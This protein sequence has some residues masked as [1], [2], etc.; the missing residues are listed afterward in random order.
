[1]SSKKLVINNIVKKFN[2]KVAVNGVSLEVKSNEITA[3]LGPNGSG[4]TTLFSIITGVISQTSGSV[5]YNDL[6]ISRLSIDKRARLGIG[7]LTQDS[8]IFKNLTVKENILFSL[9][10]KYKDKSIIKK[11]LDELLSKLKIHHIVDTEGKSLSGGEKRRV[12]VAR[13]LALDPNFLLFDEPFAGVDP[14]AIEEIKVL[15]EEIC[16]YGPGILITDHNV[17]EMINFAKNF[18]VLAS[19]ILICKGDKEK[20]LND[21]T[22]KRLYLGDNFS[23]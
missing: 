23:N 12:E 22:V 13:A 18:Y 15:I 4:K 1:M 8:S 9:Q 10:L 5:Y 6:D 2:S 14:V 3:I 17:Y 11:K 21:K 19:G 7:Y 16:S 20:I